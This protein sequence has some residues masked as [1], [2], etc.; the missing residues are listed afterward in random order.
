MSVTAARE[1][2]KRF[3]DDFGAGNV[4]GALS[5]CSE[6]VEVVDPAIGTVHGRERF[7]VYPETFSWAVPD[8]QAVIEHT[9]ESG[10]TVAVE[11]RFTGTHTGR[12]RP[13]TGCGSDR[14]G[15]RSAI[16]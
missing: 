2:V 11:G 8:A 4:D 16:R 13:M 6:D 10:D 5:A 1:R 15:G 12:S 7:R 3:Y 9:V 14:R